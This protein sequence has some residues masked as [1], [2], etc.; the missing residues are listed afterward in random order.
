M[1]LAPVLVLPLMIGR[2]F[3]FDAWGFHSGM[4]EAQAVALARIR[5]SRARS[6][7]WGTRWD[8]ARSPTP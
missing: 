4:L 2:A 7:V 3:A 1:K 8:V 5:E 6:P